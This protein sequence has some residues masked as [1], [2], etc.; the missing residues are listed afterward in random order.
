MS[1]EAVVETATANWRSSLSPEIASDPSLQHIGSVEAMAKS[2]INAQKMVGA[3]KV[4]IPGNWATDEDWGL[5][6]NKLG[7]PAAPDGY[8]L[9]DDASGDFADW[10]RNAAHGAGLSGRQAQ[11]LAAAYSEFAGQ[12]GQASE[13]QL[14]ARRSEIET[15]LRSEFGGQYDAKMERANA[16]LKEF[17]APD[18]T[19]IKLA[20]GSMLGDNPDLVRFMVRLSDYIAEQVSEDGLAGRDSRP[21]L[22]DSDI[23]ARVSEL[24]AK[25]SPYWEKMHPDHDRVVNEVLRLRE[26]LYG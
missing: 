7:R 13:E 8:E 9:G 21:T 15:E 23:N 24:T 17:E 25:N 1:D 11:Q 19:E 16:L 4:A 10:F 12:V 3:E 26:Q 6:Y 2:Y 18:L 22:S 20:D 5:V 14:D